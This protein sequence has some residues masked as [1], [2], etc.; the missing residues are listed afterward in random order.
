MEKTILE[1]LFLLLG[2]SNPLLAEN[3]NRVR[4]SVLG[5][6]QPRQLKYLFHNI[7]YDNNPSFHG[8]FDDTSERWLEIKP[9]FQKRIEHS[10]T[11]SQ[12]NS[13]EDLPIIN[14][15]TT[16]MPDITG[17]DMAFS[18]KKRH[19]SRKNFS[20]SLQYNVI[21]AGVL[22][23]FQVSPT[24][25]RDYIE[26]MRAVLV[27]SDSKDSNV[28]ARYSEI[29][30]QRRES[31]ILKMLQ[32]FDKRIE[33]ISSLQDGIYFG[34]KGFKELMPSNILGDGMRKFL[35]IITALS[36]FD[37]AIILIDEIEN[38]LHFEAHKLL[39]ESII[40]LANTYNCQ[41]CITTHNIETLS[42]LE[43]VL[44]KENY[45]NMQK[46]VKVFTLSE[47]SKQGFKAYKYSFEAFKD[48]IDTETEL[49]K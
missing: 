13:K 26:N 34:L 39:W 46:F 41:L 7:T 1:A 28:F 24:M 17:L 27:P 5:A 19:E 40:S 15:T 47:T 4:G 37:N 36:E 10:D 33:S 14:A 44:E 9:R 49:R 22:P 11:P 29:M 18:I 30:R 38:G 3:V 48:A 8:D 43:S 12:V 45:A 35:S 16:S 21:Q 2:M 31:S 25:S 42:Y 32:S 6:L 23:T 20:S